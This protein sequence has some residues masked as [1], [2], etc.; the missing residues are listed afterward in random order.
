[1]ETVYWN[2][3]HEVRPGEEHDRVYIYAGTLTAKRECGRPWTLHLENHNHDSLGDTVCSLPTAMSV[4]QMQACLTN[5]RRNLRGNRK[6]CMRQIAETARLH[7]WLD[8]S[9]SDTP[10]LFAEVTS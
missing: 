10:Y 3:D 9:M 1:M 7:A 5:C 6:E 2:V 4:E 8:A